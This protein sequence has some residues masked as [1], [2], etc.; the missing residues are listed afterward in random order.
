MYHAEYFQYM[1]LC[2]CVLEFARQQ[3]ILKQ[4]GG[5]LRGDHEWEMHGRVHPN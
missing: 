4:I 5:S 3:F 1:C 2:I